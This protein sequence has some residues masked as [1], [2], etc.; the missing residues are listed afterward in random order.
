[1]LAKLKVPANFDVEPIMAM[2]GVAR[3]GSKEEYKRFPGAT[4]RPRQNDSI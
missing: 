1:M 2:M 3:E 4:F